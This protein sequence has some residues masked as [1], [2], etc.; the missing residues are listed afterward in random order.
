V[1]AIEPRALHMLG[2]H[3]TLPPHPDSETSIWNA[4]LVLGVGCT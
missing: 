2:K 1:L 3:C 4:H